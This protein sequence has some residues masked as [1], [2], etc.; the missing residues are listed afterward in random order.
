LQTQIV[1]AFEKL[2]ERIDGLSKI[3]IEPPTKHPIVFEEKK[4]EEKPDEA[5]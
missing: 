2:S 4:E 1:T 5:L 3:Q